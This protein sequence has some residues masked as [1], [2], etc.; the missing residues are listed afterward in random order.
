MPDRLLRAV[1]NLLSGSRIFL[2]AGFIMADAHAVRLGLIGVAGLTDVLDGF[3]A[4]RVNAAT[5]WGALIDPVAD[6]VFALAAIAT[7]LFDG[8]VTVPQYFVLI[9]R[10]LMTAIGFLVARAVPMLRPVTFKAR[11]IGKAV[12]VLQFL[13]LGSALAYRPALAPLLLLVLVAS[14]VSIADYT[15]ALWR[16]SRTA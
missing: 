1:P 14:V 12:T 8:L 11:G 10:D 15:W 4:R 13:A 16:A 2:A 9:L 3:V 7:L 6:R 5:R